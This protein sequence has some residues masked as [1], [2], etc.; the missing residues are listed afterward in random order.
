MSLDEAIAVI[1]PVCLDLKE[2][3]ARGEKLY[4]HPSA[5]AP[6]ADGLARLNPRLSLVPTQRPRQALPRPRAP[7]HARAG[8]RLLQRLLPRRD[9]L[10]DGD[11]PAH[12]PR[13]E[14]PARHR[15]VAARGARESSSARPS[16]ASAR[17][18]RRTSARSRARMYHVA[19]QKSIHPPDISEARLDAE[20]RARRRRE[21]LDASARSAA[22]EPPERERRD[23]ACPGPPRTPRSTA[24]TRSA[25][26]S[27]IAPVR[28]V[29]PQVGRRPDRAP[30]RAQG[31][32][33]ER[34]RARATSSARTRWTTAPSRPWSCSSR[35]PR[36][37][38]PRDHGLR[39]EISGQ[40][41]PIA[42]WEEFAPFAEQ[43]GL[44]REKRAEEKA[45]V[46][47]AD[48]DKKRGVAKSIVAVSVVVAL[49][50]VLAVW[51]LK[52]RG[53]HNDDV[54][55]RGRS[56]AAPSRSTATSRARRRRRRAAAAAA[57]RGRGFSGRQRAS[58]T[59][60]TTT[61][62]RITMGQAQDQ[63]DLTNA[64]LA[65][66]APSR[67]VHHRLRRARTT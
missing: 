41:L 52:V 18:A 50:G 39:D 40:S 55:G 37:P 7:A 63:P 56:R 60:S 59:S 8:R 29:Q 5:I 16:S 24:A 43:A 11:G 20:R 13:D 14:A 27:S 49:A 3:H 34:S 54:V 62:R 21:V 45:V 6:G 25:A 2:R 30:R 28:A 66:P 1:V 51:F 64:Q 57:G 23:D 44:L 58:R 9:A 26:P 32:A 67:V 17:T 15:A 31:E 53:T 48:A 61:T 35:S 36:T 12:R 4:V 46:R 22:R 19:P 33:R 42:E 65:A 47:A 38:S 10:R